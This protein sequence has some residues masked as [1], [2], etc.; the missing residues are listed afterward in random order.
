MAVDVVNQPARRPVDDFKA[1]SKL[2][3]RFVLRP[4]CDI[5]EAVFAGGNPIIG[6]D[7]IGYAFR[8]YFFRAAGELCSIRKLRIQ[9]FLYGLFAV[10]E[11]QPIL[12]KM[13]KTGAGQFNGLCR[14]DGRCMIYNYKIFQSYRHSRIDIRTAQIVG[15]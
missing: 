2:R 7:R 14:N 6:A 11:I 4:G 8:L 9:E 3:Q 1:F 10:D 15:I 5:A 12:A 13:E